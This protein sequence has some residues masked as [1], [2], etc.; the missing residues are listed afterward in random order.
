M[1]SNNNE[2][3][4]IG[5]TNDLL[6]RVYEHKNHLVEGF[7]KRYNATKLVY[8]E[9]TN[10]INVAGEREKK[11]K[12]RHRAYKIRLIEKGN[13]EWRDLAEDFW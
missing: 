8:F 1:A 13:P 9:E 6:R 3:L 12:N 2:V 7:T 11:L 10:D 4:Y 5:S